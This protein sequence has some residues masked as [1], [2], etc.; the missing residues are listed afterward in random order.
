LYKY[1]LV[2]LLLA[3]E[4]LPLP[5]LGE[6]APAEKGTTGAK[7]HEKKTEATAKDSVTTHQVKIGGRTLSYTATAGQLPVVGESGEKE[8][9]IFY[10]Y[11]SAGSDKQ[12]QQRP[13]MF[14]FNGGPG[15]AAVWLHLGAVGP[16]RVE[17]LPDGNMPA[18]P[19][20]LV[21]NES[22]WLD[23]ADL[24]FVDP[25]GTGYSRATTPDLAKKF[26]AVRGDIECL[27]RFVRLFLTRYQRWTSPLF[28][29]GES[30]GTFRSAGLSDYLLE[31]GVA[32]NGMVLVSTILNLQTTSFDNGNDLPYQLFL[33]SYTATAWYHNKL[34]PELQQDLDKTLEQA[35]RWAAT[36]YQTALNQGDRLSVEER[37]KVAEQ[38]GR[39]TG[40]STG[41]VD[42]MNLRVDS[43]TFVTQLL[44]DRR[45][46]VGYMDSRFTAASV[47]PGGGAGFDPTVSTIRPPFTAAMN[48]YARDELGYQSDLEYFTLGGGIGRWDWETKNGYADTS[49]NLRSSLAKNPYMKVLVASGVFDLATPHFAAEYTMAHLGV[50]PDLRKN[51]TM[52]RYR[53]GHMMYL[54]GNSLAELKRDVAG[55]VTQTLK[56]HGK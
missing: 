47:E 28:V 54:E 36:E 7:A 44:H 51:I 17:M 31:H 15:A 9:D 41:F 46:T 16:R 49:D 38:L 53:S 3:V 34:A 55:F 23:L 27:G 42:G 24:V 32:L 5:A 1:L 6:G 45:R 40:L 20:H 11:Y 29:V 2:L 4:L 21:D 25:I 13:L 37:K 18:P 10:V 56:E 35:E 52:R 22:S 39:F 14:L 12:R 26:T 50:T 30:Y 19:F 43:R 8:A 48:S 33:P